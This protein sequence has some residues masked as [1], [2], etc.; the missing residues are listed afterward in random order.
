MGKKKELR[1]QVL[2]LLGEV[3]E[4]HSIM[5]RQTAILIQVA[6]ALNGP[7]PEGTLWSHHDLAEKAR[8][9]VQMA[10]GGSW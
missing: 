6:N 2:D 5:M 3:D 10:G 7:P 8:R 9:L 4:Y 1:K